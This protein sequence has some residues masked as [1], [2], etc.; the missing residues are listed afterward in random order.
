MGV[1]ERVAGQKSSS[2]RFVSPWL[3]RVSLVL[4]LGG[5]GGKFSPATGEPD[6]G[7]AAA[8][9]SG[10]SSGTS[11]S[12]G[13]G[14]GGSGGSGGG[15]SGSS[16]SSGDSGPGD[17][18]PPDVRVD[19]PVTPP[20]PVGGLILWLRADMGINR[21]T[22]SVAAWADQSSAGNDATQPALAL[23]PRFVAAGIAGNPSVDFN[24]TE[25]FLMLPSGFSDF[26][27]GISMFVVTLQHSSD[28]CSALIQL[29]N[30]SE[31]DDITLGQY[32]GQTL[33]EVADE[34]FSGEAFPSGAVQLLA[35]VHG[36]DGAF[37]LRRNGRPSSN[38][39]SALPVEIERT[40][41]VV[42]DSLYDSCGTFAG[43]IAEVLVYA[44]AVSTEELFTIERYLRDRSGI[45]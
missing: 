26:T 7:S 33:Y 32:N 20:V 1:L 12:G 17:S 42:G 21:E 41:N 24:G 8:A 9:G 18:S 2:G 14:S 40:R 10:G 5:C 37:V 43:Q 6:S 31:I 11:G 30:G 4:L 16:G 15:G 44:R 28:R 27:D 25:D 39:M 13:G 45:Q 3:F 35:L 22:D 34:Y 29:S 38:G 23:R 19:V 36:A